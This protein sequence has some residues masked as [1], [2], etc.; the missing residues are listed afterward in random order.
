MPLTSVPTDLSFARKQIPTMMLNAFQDVTEKRCMKWSSTSSTE[1]I[2]YIYCTSW[3][4]FAVPAISWVSM[5]RHC[6]LVCGLNGRKTKRRPQVAGAIN[7]A[8]YKCV[9]PTTVVLKNRELLSGN[10][11]RDQTISLAQAEPIRLQQLRGQKPMKFNNHL[12]TRALRCGCVFSQRTLIYV[13]VE[14]CNNRTRN[15]VH[16]YHRDNPDITLT[17]LAEAARD[18]DIQTG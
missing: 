6:L 12:W 16:R 14:G 1:T 7:E 17:M 13:F 5:R 2:R 9:R 15:L 3:T 4:L 11:R 18:F 10:A 8:T